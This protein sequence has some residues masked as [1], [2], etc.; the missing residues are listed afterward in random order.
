MGR[1]AARP[2]VLNP[3]EPAKRAAMGARRKT[4]GPPMITLQLPIDQKA[5]RLC[6]TWLSAPKR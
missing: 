2:T 3:S 5:V 4:P 6:L 1:P